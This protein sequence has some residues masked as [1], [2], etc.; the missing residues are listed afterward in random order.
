MRRKSLKQ[1]P[2]RVHHDAAVHTVKA[3]MRSFYKAVGE[4]RKTF[5]LVQLLTHSVLCL[6]EIHL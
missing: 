4:K 6:V 5:K 1:T 3:E 2:E